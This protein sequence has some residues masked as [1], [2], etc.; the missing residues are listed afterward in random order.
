MRT[1]G[2]GEHHALR[3]LARQGHHL[4]PQRRDDDRRELAHTFHRM[5]LLDE[6]TRV[7]ERLADGDT[8]ALMARCMCHTDTETEATAGHLV[9]E[10]GA[11]R[12]IQYG[13]RVDRR[14][15][16]AERDALRVPRHRLT[17][18]HVAVHAGCVDASEAAP[19][20]VA[21]DIH[22]E[23]AATGDSDEGD[24]GKGHGGSLDWCSDQLIALSG[25]GTGALL[26]LG[27]THEPGSPSG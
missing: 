7:A 19:L 22:G 12:E 9:H 14:D 23:T 5:Q 21:R 24:G 4:L 1:R 6:G 8:H 13:A 17:L 18:R 20:D 2:I 15:G 11:L 3:N 25:I 10:C 26:R 16:G 27:Q